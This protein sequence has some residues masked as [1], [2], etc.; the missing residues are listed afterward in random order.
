M[1][2]RVISF[3][4]A[5]ILLATPVHVLAEESRN[6]NPDTSPSIPY[7]RDEEPFLPLSVPLDYSAI[8]AA[9]RERQ[10]A[11]HE[12][13]QSL[14]IGVARDEEPFRPLPLLPPTP[15][16]IFDK[17]VAR[18][19]TIED[20]RRHLTEEEIH[21]STSPLPKSPPLGDPSNE[22]FTDPVTT[23]QRKHGVC[24][25]LAL[26]FAAFFSG[27]NGYRVHIAVQ[28]PLDAKGHFLDAKGHVVALYRHPSGK[29]GYSS[30]TEVSEPIFETMRDASKDTL[31]GGYFSPNIPVSVSISK[32]LQPG[33]WIDDGIPVRNTIL[34]SKPFIVMSK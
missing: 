2:L 26:Y 32:A 22:H 24:D 7:A 11:H 9:R 13:L 5:G 23:Y 28:R 27:K 1:T 18:V 3:G 6:T 29:W 17:L 33:R 21:Y 14:V 8:P 16:E 19:N 34:K 31:E 25:E 12:Y 15:R 10:R 30:N 20:Y 4:L